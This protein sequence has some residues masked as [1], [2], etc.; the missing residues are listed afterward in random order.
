MQRGNRLKTNEEDVES[1]SVLKEIKT[2][3]IREHI[4]K[5]LKE[6]CQRN[7][8]DSPK[9]NMRVTENKQ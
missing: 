5:R 7:D 8:L 9:T 3:P 2:N 6:V 1:G 4:I